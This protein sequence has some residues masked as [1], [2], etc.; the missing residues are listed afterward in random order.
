[1]VRNDRQEAERQLDLSMM[2]SDR[3]GA[4]TWV[5]DSPGATIRKGDVVA[6]IAD[7]SSFRVDAS[8]SGRKTAMTSCMR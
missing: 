6:R 5:I 7:L 2:R 8:I 4:I 1:M 3:D